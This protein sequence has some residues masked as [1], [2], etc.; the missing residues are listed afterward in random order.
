[1]QTKSPTTQIEIRTRR[2]KKMDQIDWIKEDVIIH[3]YN[4]SG[5]K[6]IY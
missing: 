1:M 4:E 5:D 2:I 3:L 6:K